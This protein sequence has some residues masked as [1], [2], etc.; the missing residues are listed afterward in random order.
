MVV[1]PGVG[2]GAQ[3]YGPTIETRKKKAPQCCKDL[4]VQNPTTSEFIHHDTDSESS[5]ADSPL[6]I[7]VIILL[8]VV[9]LPN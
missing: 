1:S 4:H 8:V 3:F 2:G 9:Y 6:M 7:Y 5:P